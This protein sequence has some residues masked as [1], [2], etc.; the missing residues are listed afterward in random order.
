MMLFYIKICYKHS[1]YIYY[2]I[3]QMDGEY[4]MR[5]IKDKIRHK[6]TI[7]EIFVTIL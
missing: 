4:F 6:I 5:F 3:N 7:T 2:D 1:F